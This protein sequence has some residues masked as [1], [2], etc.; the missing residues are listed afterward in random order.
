MRSDRRALAAGLFRWAGR[1]AAMVR[2]FLHDTR[3]GATAIVAAGV[4]IMTMGGVGLLIDHLWLVHKRDLVKAASDSA[5]VAATLALQQS[6][7]SDAEL[8]DIAERYVRL[9]VLANLRAGRELDPGEIEVTLDVDRAVG[10]VG[11]TAKAPIGGL[12][13]G[14]L[15]RLSGTRGHHDRLRRGARYAPARGHA[16]RRREPVDAMGF[17]RRPGRPVAPVDC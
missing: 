13:M 5:A 4:I 14:F 1:I 15:A 3:A 11:V 16:R 9:N 12:L 8:Q 2:A 6:G 17:A 10:T 7:A